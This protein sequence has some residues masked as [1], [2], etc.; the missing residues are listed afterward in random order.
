MK[1][2][3]SLSPGGLLLPYHIGCLAALSYHGHI[4]DTTSLAGSSAGAIAVA[5]H[6]SGVDPVSALKASIRVAEKCY[7]NP[8]MIASGGLLP[9]LRKELNDLLPDDAHHRLNDREGVVGLA[10]RELFPRNQARLTTHFQ[11]RKCL[12][13]AI[14]DSSTFPFFLT[15]QPVRAV[16]RIDEPVPR[17]VVDGVFACPMENLGCPEL[18]AS[19]VAANDR[20]RVVQ[21]SVFP[22]QLLSFSKSTFS[23]YYGSNNKIGPNL[24]LEPHKLAVQTANLARIATQGSTSRELSNL[25]ENGWADAERWSNQEMHDRRRQRELQI[26]CQRQY[27]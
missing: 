18:D 7:F 24:E 23:S 25:Y 1:V 17:I 16:Q 12:M 4:T 21:I 27:Q 3:F 2:A 13:D 9:C 26:S 8:L 6:A 15:N 11:T 10:H 19:S 5:S 14:C 22:K 20:K